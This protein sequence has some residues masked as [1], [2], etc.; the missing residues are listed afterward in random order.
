MELQLVNAMTD[1]LESVFGFIQGVYG[2]YFV[3][4]ALFF[5]AVVIGIYMRFFTKLIRKNP[6]TQ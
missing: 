5:V 1:M 2:G 4:T 3:I 6:S